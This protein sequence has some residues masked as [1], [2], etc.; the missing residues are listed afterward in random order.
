M[1]SKHLFPNE[2]E[3]VIIRLL[4]EPVWNRNRESMSRLKNAASLLIEPVW[5]RNMSGLLSHHR[6][7][8]SFN[9]TSMESKLSSESLFSSALGTF[10]R[11]SMESKLWTTIDNEATDRKPFNRTS[12]ES[13]LSVCGHARNC[14]FFF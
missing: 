7:Q 3:R 2:I 6:L 8:V 14:V 5:N 9:R 11:T 13:K 10:N 4:I 12:L 1:E